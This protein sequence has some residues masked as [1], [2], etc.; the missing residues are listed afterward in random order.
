MRGAASTGIWSV[1]A[2]LAVSPILLVV[3][4]TDAQWWRNVPF[5]MFVILPGVVPALLLGP[6]IAYRRWRLM[7]DEFRAPEPAS[8][9]RFPTAD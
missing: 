7:R 1:L 4:A 8:E 9:S 2:L 6:A 3:V 5:W